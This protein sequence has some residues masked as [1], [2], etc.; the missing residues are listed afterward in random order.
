MHSEENVKVPMHDDLRKWMPMACPEYEAR[1]LE[2]QD[3]ILPADDRRV[4]EDHMA[5]CKACLRFAEGLKQLDSELAAVCRAASLSPQF[6]AR[7]MQRIDQEVTPM[8]AKALA[9]RKDELESEFQATMANLMQTVWR[10][11]LPSLLDAL[12]LAT[13][14]VIAVFVVRS[15]L[16]QMPSLE[17]VCALMTKGTYG[18]AALALASAGL[19]A[20]V[21]LT[22]GRRFLGRIPMRLSA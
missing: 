12:G 6:K 14:A 3:G 16:G 10:T 18:P 19:A 1:I 11:N 7:L 5:V 13:V 2:L 21:V 9:A 15:V 17:A 8:S 4:V 22:V 20:G